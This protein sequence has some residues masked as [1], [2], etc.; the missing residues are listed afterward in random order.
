MKLRLLRKDISTDGRHA[1]VKFSKD[2]KKD[3]S[4]RDFTIN[5]IYSDREG[6]LFDPFDGKEDLEKGLVNFIGK[7]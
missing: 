5:A 1:K 3:A 2:W 4:R 6:N 7:C